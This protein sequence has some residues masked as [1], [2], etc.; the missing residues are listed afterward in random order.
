MVRYNSLW[1]S[2]VATEKR[3]IPAR[4]TANFTGIGTRVSAMNAD[5]RNKR[6]R[7][8]E[9]HLWN[10]EIEQAT[11]RAFNWHCPFCNAD[12]HQTGYHKAHIHP[13]GSGIGIVPGNIVLACPACN[14][15]MHSR[16]TW[17]WCDQH[18][19][20][21]WQIQFTLEIVRRIY[22]PDRDVLKSHKVPDA[23]KRVQE[24]YEQNKDALWDETLGVRKVAEHL[25]V[26][27]QTVSNVRQA[28]RDQAKQSNGHH[29]E[30]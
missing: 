12:L 18:N 20:S 8:A 6:A 17:L 1:Q 28:L 15:D 27:R 9:P 14:M 10:D 25:G 4:L 24:F 23:S 21:Y 26:G 29:V 3:D 11:G 19:I 2:R 16:P 5:T 7:R 30:G 22:M 13:V